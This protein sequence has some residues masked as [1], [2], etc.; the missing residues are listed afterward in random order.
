VSSSIN[1]E[2]YLNDHSIPT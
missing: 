2:G 1:D